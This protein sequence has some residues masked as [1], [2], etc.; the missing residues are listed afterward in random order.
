MNELSEKTKIL[1]VSVL[2][3]F[4]LVGSGYSEQSDLAPGPHRIV[5]DSLFTSGISGIEDRGIG[6]LDK[7][8]L[9]NMIT[10]FGI[11]ADHH[12]GT[13]ALHWPKDGTDVQQY[14]FGVSLIVLANGQVISSIPDPSSPSQNYGWEAA[15]GYINPDRNEDN[16]AGDGVTPLLA[17]SDRRATWPINGGNPVWPGFFRTDITN[18]SEVVAN[19]FFSDRDIYSVF[20]D[21]YELGLKVEQIGHSYSRPY[22]EDFFFLRYRVNNEGPSNLDTVRIGLLADI[23]TDF[24]DDDR[25]GAWDITPHDFPG[26]PSFIFKQDLNGLPQR[27]DSSDF[28]DSW[29]GPVAWAGVGI[30]DGP[31]IINLETFHYFHD[32]N[33]PVNPD[34]LKAVMSGDASSLEHPEWYFHSETDSTFDDL[35]R[36]DEIDNNEFPGTEITFLMSSGEFSLDVGEMKEFSL[37]FVMGEDSTDLRKNVDMAYKMANETYYQGSGPPPTPSLYATAGDGEILLN[38]DNASENGLDALTGENDFE[39]YRIYK[40]T[41]QGESWGSVL[42]NWYG[43]PVGYLPLYQ[44]DKIDSITGLD[45]AYSPDFPSAHAFLGDDTGLRHS[46]RD[47]DVIN[48]Q[49]VWYT[50]TAYD[51]GIYNPDLGQ[52]EQSYETSRGLSQF[53]ATTV[54]VTPSTQVTN[55]VDGLVHQ[56]REVNGR[57]YD[58]QLEIEIVDDSELNGHDYQI[59]FIEDIVEIVPDSFIVALKLNLKDVTNNSSTFLDMITGETVEYDSIPMNGDDLPVVDGFR[60]LAKN[61]EAPGVRDMGWSVVNGLECTFDWWTENRYVGNPSSYEEVVYGNDD[62]RITI[63]NQSTEFRTTIVGFT[64]EIFDTT[65]SV[66]MKVERDDG[67]GWVDV[68]EHVLLSDLRFQWPE[69]QQISPLGYDFIPGGL[70]YAP[71]G[72]PDLGAMF[73]DIIVLRDDENDDIGSYIWLKTNNGPV[74]ATPLSIGDVFEIITLKSF[75]TDHL[76][77]FTTEAPSLSGNSNLSN[78]KAVPNPVIVN[79]GFGSSDDS[80]VMFTHLPAK[81]E[82]SIYTVAGS[83]VK[84]VR[85]NASANDGYAYWDLRNEHGQDVAYGLY[86]YVVTTPDDKKF[87][88][89]VML[90]R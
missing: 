50:I 57:E 43:D 24:Y 31:T 62:W 33:T 38:W 13:P 74:T 88:G 30:V 28:S 47:S 65:F 40:S 52:V 80:Q 85:H 14:A 2:M 6:L 36:Q 86:V 58:G 56:L 82:I 21:K 67:L 87:T 79:S 3:L 34:D 37:V 15:S 5:A 17:S 9:S 27:Q 11:I 72:N 73:P 18:P 71:V 51:R 60:I 44:C 75:S 45:P 29:N 8:Q 16:S 78:I 61:L 26:Y 76:F 77:E 7:G 63:E 84:T 70:S 42:T 55:R 39:G 83:K 41:D 22:A 54:A 23:K 64:D 12:T 20:E 48:G 25:I 32:D 35:D 59:T 46:Y 69:S 68:T 1:L 90:I 89:K 49:E 66:P 4:V 53:D 19:E 10:N 81:C